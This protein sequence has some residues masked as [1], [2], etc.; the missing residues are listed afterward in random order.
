MKKE[1]A[2]KRIDKMERHLLF[3][4]RDFTNEVHKILNQI[5]R[6]KNGV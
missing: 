2:Q 6:E 3:V 4:I 1:Q 5:E